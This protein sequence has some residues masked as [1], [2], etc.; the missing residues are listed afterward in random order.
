MCKI[1]KFI[2]LHSIQWFHTPVQGELHV[3]P[4]HRLKCEEMKLKGM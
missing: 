4:P 2:A 1:Y 3:T